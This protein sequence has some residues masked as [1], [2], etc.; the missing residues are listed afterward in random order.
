MMT[1]LTYLEA[2]APYRRARMAS[3]LTTVAVLAALTGLASQT[4]CGRYHPDQQ[5]PTPPPRTP[6][7]FPSPTGALPAGVPDPRTVNQDDPTALSRAAAITMW[8]IDAYTDHGGQHDAD[9][10]TAP[11]L[12][13]AY[14]RQITSATDNVP[15]PDD[16][17]RQ[18]LHTVVRAQPGSEDAPADSPTRAYRQWRLTITYVDGAGHQHG[19]QQYVA[20]YLTLVR[21]AQQ[22][23]RISAM[24]PPT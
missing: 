17:I 16:W 11:Y 6:T 5:P 7:P 10:R 24:T 18:R 3:R 12:T 8:S 19:S 13:P 2:T 21:S 9:L 15:L 14:A 20:V 1:A 22:P 4:G 23:W